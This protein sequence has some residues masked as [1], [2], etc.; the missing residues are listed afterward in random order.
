MH[1]GQVSLV[2]FFQEPSRIFSSILSIFN[3][4]SQIKVQW[5]YKSLFLSGSG[6]LGRDPRCFTRGILISV[7]LL[8]QG[9]TKFSRTLF[10]SMYIYQVLTLAYTQ[11]L[12][13]K[14]VEQSDKVEI[15]KKIPS[16]LII[17][18]NI[19]IHRT[20]QYSLELRD[21]EL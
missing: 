11:S 14:I 21:Q 13:C 9:S 6:F 18:G 2:K 4:D 20:K 19:Y 8:Y 16:A 15:R 1:G 7:S 5:T 12:A 10:K 3:I 17:G